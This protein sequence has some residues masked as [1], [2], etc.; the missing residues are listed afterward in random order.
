MIKLFATIT[1]PR[2][3]DVTSQTFRMYTHLHVRFMR[4]ITHVK[5]Q[6]GFVIKAVV[7]VA[8]DELP[9]F[10]RDARLRHSVYSRSGHG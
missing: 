1:A 4:D 10:R 9:E 6:M 7:V 5:S 8:K 3:E 2:T